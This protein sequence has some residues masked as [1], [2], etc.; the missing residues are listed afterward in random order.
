MY[1][2]SFNV[3]DVD[4]MD[5]YPYREVYPCAYVCVSACVHVCVCFMCVCDASVL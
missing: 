4:N 2:I 3:D 5:M 1:V